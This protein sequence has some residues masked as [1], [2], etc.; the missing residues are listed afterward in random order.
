MNLKQQP[1]LPDLFAVSKFRLFLKRLHRFL[2]DISFRPKSCENDLIENI[3]IGY[4][5]DF[6]FGLGYSIPDNPIED[7]CQNEFDETHIYQPVS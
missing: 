7:K 6:F 2:F 5:R 1:S 3:F 4:R